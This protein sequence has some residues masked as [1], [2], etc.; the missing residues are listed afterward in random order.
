M[1]FSVLADLVNL[2][3]L[4][5]MGFCTTFHGNPFNSDKVAQSCQTGRSLTS[6]ENFP[7]Q[8]DRI[9]V[10]SL[11]SSSS[12]SILSLTVFKADILQPWATLN[13]LF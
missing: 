11:S 9:H 5:V 10:S 12:P 3:I 13:V 1:C 7:L 6:E 4:A 2:L 8:C